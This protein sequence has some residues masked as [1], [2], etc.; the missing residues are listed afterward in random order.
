MIKHKVFPR[1]DQEKE[2]AKIEAEYNVRKTTDSLKYLNVLKDEEV[3]QKKLERNGYVLA[4]T[5]TGI[6]GIVF[7]N[8]KRQRQV[9][10]RKEAEAEKRRVEDLARLQLNEF[11]RS[12][13]EK[14]ELIEKFSA[15]IKKYQALPCSNELPKNEQALQELQSAVILTDEQWSSFQSLFDTVHPGY[16]HRVREKYHTLT[17]ADLRFLVLTKLRLNNKEMAAMFG[18]SL[19]AI[20]ASKHRLLK[21]IQLPE[22]TSVDEVVHSI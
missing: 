19:E 1:I 3:K 13:Q 18:V 20:R 11:T 2:F 7:V 9:Q 4:A 16:I 5:F 10:R 21:K 14:N 6:L 15:E 12:I 17:S 8:R 22:G